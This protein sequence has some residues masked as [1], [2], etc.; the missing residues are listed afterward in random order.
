MASLTYI[1]FYL[2]IAAHLVA[3]AAVA[4]YLRGH[5]ADAM[6]VF[7]QRVTGAGVVLLLL[8][9]MIRYYRWRLFPLSTAVDALSLFVLLSSCTALFISRG[10]RRALLAI[11]SP[12]LAGLAAAAGISGFYGLNLE[13]KAL[14]SALLLTHVGLVFLAF[15]LYFVASLT[16]LAYLDQ[17][18]RLKNHASGGL[19]AKLPSLENLDRTLYRL[20]QVGYPVF[21]VALV[22]GAFWAW[23]ERDLLDSGWWKSPKIILAVFMCGVFSVCFHARRRG[24]LRGPK[25][26][27]FVFFGVAVV[28]GLFVL[29]RVLDLSNLN[30]YKVAG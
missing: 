16:S 26:A 10:E 30:F 13:P 6:L 23:Y 5:R 8:T 7:A 21:S 27:K 2:A 22:L 1:S 29:L 14:S 24:W 20:I 9:L 12:P 17:A 18:R 28:L 11:Y 4:G 3:A 15:S 25:L 19:F